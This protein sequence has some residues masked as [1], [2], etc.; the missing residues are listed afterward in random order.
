MAYAGDLKSSAREGLRVRVPSPASGIPKTKICRGI[1]HK[2]GVELPLNSFYFVHYKTF[3]GY[4][5]L[6]KRCH[7]ASYSKNGIPPEDRGFVAL[8]RVRWVFEEGIRKVGFKEFSRRSGI[9]ATT[10]WKIRKNKRRYI[11]KN[12]A[13]KGMR[14]LKEIRDARE[15][16]NPKDIARG[17]QARGE[18][19]KKLVGYTWVREQDDVV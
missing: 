18:P 15:V 9:G 2:K 16:R 12:T 13:K 11:Q 6:C 7:C 8:S 17:R 19:E 14:A 5:P 3:T 1:L 4:R 10:L